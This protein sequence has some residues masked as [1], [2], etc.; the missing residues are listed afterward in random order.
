MNTKKPEDV[1]ASPGSKSSEL[2]VT[3]REISN[4]IKTIL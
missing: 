2:S 4:I 1:P 3:D